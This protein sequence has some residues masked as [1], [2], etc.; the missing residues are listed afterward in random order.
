MGRLAFRTDK[1]SLLFF[2]LTLIGPLLFAE[3]APYVSIYDDTSDSNFGRSV[4]RSVIRGVRLDR[5]SHYRTLPVEQ[6]LLEGPGQEGFLTPL[7]LSDEKKQ[8]LER[9]TYWGITR[10]SD[11]L[12]RLRRSGVDITFSLEKAGEDLYREIEDYYADWP[13]W[14]EP[15]RNH[16]QANWVIRI[17]RAE[18]VFEPWIDL[19]TYNEALLA[20]TLIAD[21]DQWLWGVHDGAD[22]LEW[23]FSHP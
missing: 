14:Y 2:I 21:E 6:S 9:G 12:Y 1:K 22:F 23:G 17:H 8:R 10:E 15:V 11:R 7:V 16:Y 4:A 13:E 19:I 18:N 20:A 3:D 5:F